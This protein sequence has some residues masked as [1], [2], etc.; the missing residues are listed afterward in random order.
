M[1]N[2]LQ[3]NH[4]NTG[5]SSVMIF[6]LSCYR[7]CDCETRSHIVIIILGLRAGLYC[8]C[9][10]TSC[11]IGGALE[12]SWFYLWVSDLLFWAC[13]SLCLQHL[14]RSVLNKRMD[15]LFVSSWWRQRFDPLSFKLTLWHF[16][17]LSTILHLP[18]SEFTF[19]KM[20]ESW[21][22]SL[23]LKLDEGLKSGSSAVSLLMSQETWRLAGLDPR[24]DRS[25]SVSVRPCRG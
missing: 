25:A 2:I 11:S 5:M 13:G 9:E 17:S 22:F 8:L 10:F 21:L 3:M 16:H 4:T 18:F 20:P 7:S 19:S 15:F 6:I 12:L 24:L 1:V 23:D 14:Q